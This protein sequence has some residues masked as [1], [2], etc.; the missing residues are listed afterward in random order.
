M[1]LGRLKQ[2][3]GLLKWPRELFRDHRGIQCMAERLSLTRPYAC[4]VARGNSTPMPD[5]WCLEA[6][7]GVEFG[8]LCTRQSPTCAARS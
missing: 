4:Y 7:N 5:R 2:R 3:I 8:A 1:A 6:G